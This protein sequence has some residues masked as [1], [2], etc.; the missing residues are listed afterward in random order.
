VLVF[1]HGGGWT[2]GDRAQRAGGAE[3]IRNIGRFFASRG[4]G[5]AVISYRLQPDVTWR[6]QVADVGRAVGWVQHAV[7]RWGGR[8][9]A[10]FLSGHS[11]GAHLSARF[12]LDPAARAA[13]GADV[14]GLILVSGAAYDLADAETYAL[15]ADRDYF[16]ARFR[17][18]GDADWERHASVVPL[19]GPQSA[20]ALVV[21]ASGEPAKLRRQSD[22]L[23]AAYRRVGAPVEQVVVPG[24]DHERIVLTLSRD[25]KTAAPAMLDFIR[26]T[27]CDDAE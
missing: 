21:Y 5:A 27:A 16:E 23:V 25:D 13:A 20:P 18:P 4:V 1:V 17:E 24:E 3:V 26:G 9:E 15:G 7:G 10:L 11:A 2:H 22:L 6:D 12:A 19:V 8:P 14:C